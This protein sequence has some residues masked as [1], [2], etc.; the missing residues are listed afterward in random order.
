MASIAS[1]IVLALTCSSCENSFADE[2]KPTPEKTDDRKTILFIAGKPSHGNGE[3]EFRAGCMLLADALNESGLNLEAKVHYYG[4]PKDE[5]IFDGVDTCVIYADAGGRFGEKYAFLDKK[6]KQDGMGIMFMHYGVHPKKEVG[7]KYFKPWIGGYMDNDISV[8]P[9]WIADVQAVAAEEVSRGLE[10]PFTAYDEFYFNMKF[11]TKEECDCCRPLATATPTPDR[12]IKYINMWNKHGEENL[13]KEQALMWCRDPEVSE[14]GRGVGF[15]GGHYHHNWAI[16]DFRKLV[17]NAIVWSARMEVPEGGVNS[18]TVTKEMINANLDRPVKGKPIELPTDELLKQ[19]PMPQPWFDKDGKRQ[20]GPAP[21]QELLPINT[22]DDATE[23]APELK[24]EVVG[25]EH[26]LIP[27]DSNLEVTLWASSPMLY[28]PTNMDIDKDGRIWVA[29]AVNYRRKEGRRPGGDRIVVL[30]DT[31]GDGKADTS[32]TFVEDVE[33]KAP[34]GVSVFDN[35]IVV[36]MP[37]NMLVYTDVDRDLKFDP[38]IDKKEILMS[39]FNALQ[40]DHSLHSVTH[41]PDGKWYFNNG[42]CGAIFTDKSGKTFNMNGIYRGGGGTWFAENNKL[43]GKK[44]DDGF[45]WTSGFSVRVNPDGTDAEITGHGYRNS[46]EHSVNSLGDIFQN[47]N[48]DVGSCRSSYILEYG[49]AG[50]HT[51]DG[52]QNWRSVRRPGQLLIDAHWRQADPGT[53]DTGDVYGMGSPTGNVFYENGALGKEWEGTFFSCEAARNVVFGYRPKADKAT[54]TMD[55]FD[56]LDSNKDKR[57]VGG[58][59]TR[60]KMAEIAE[61]AKRTVLFRPSDVAVGPD[62]AIYVTDWYDGRVG[63]HTTLDDTCS[64]AIYRIAPKGFKSVIPEFDIETTAGQ[65]EALKSPAVNVRHSGFIGLR[66]GGEKSYD[67]VVALLNDSNEYIAARAIWLLPYLGEKGMA[68]CVELLDSENVDMKLVAYRALR[69][70][71]EGILPYAMKLASDPSDA[72][73]RDVALSLRQHTA[74]ET[75]DIFVELAKHVDITDK[76]SVEAIGL[77][78]ENKE[79]AIWEAIKASQEKQDPEEWTDTFAKLTWRLWPTDAVQ[80]LTKRALS[81]KVSKTQR[82]LATESLAFIDD[83]SAAEAMFTLAGKDSP[84]KDQAAYW[85]LNRGTGSWAKFDI[86]AQLKDRG[87]YDPE[88]IVVNEM[89][90]PTPPEQSALPPV[91]EILKLTGDPEKGKTAIMRCVQCHSINGVGPQYGPQLQGWGASQSR[92]AIIN[93]IRNP[94]ADIAHGFRGSRITT[95][96]GKVVD[97]LVSP[98][99]PIVIT[100]MGGVSQMIPKEKIKSN[101]GL[102]RSLMLSADQLG[103]SAQDIADIASYMQQWK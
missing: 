52:Q 26:F 8:N 66:D 69:R 20:K 98:G 24:P 48:D 28:N 71:E 96:D 30:Q 103:L 5:S 85:L 88:K 62:G 63:G 39:G 37:P 38:K 36:P 102:G 99:D 2:A 7:E 29:E 4:W 77:G 68:K 74:D 10:K 22:N 6:V 92:E 61:D 15:V 12:I 80:D 94:S 25:L 70:T 56:F 33:I 76:N 84:V 11:P 90:F 51:R 91:A 14:G 46:Y 60:L 42:N 17:L 87:I 64:G 49:S 47:D 97:G 16:D 57:Y 83:R 78:A 101:K 81:S 93:S 58:D 41:G 72:I 19:K 75:K 13:G 43:N 1:L 67:A 100:S 34:L 3:H 31:N 54:Y 35:K 86:K 53:F 89:K 44:S 21:K 65:I 40:H 27:E 95:K 73:R 50:W 59:Q 45:L 32:H 82:E 23:W 9:H 18:K 55:R 79:N